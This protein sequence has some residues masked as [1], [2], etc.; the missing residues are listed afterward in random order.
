MLTFER[1]LEVFKDYLAED[2]M[3]EV[4]HTSHGYAILEWDSH[5]K[6][7]N[8]IQHCET[9]EEMRD[10]LLDD[11]AGFM[12]YKITDAERD[13]TEEERG[14]IQFQRQTLMERCR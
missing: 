6:D 1:V 3:Y 10:F 8:G 2:D 11:F 9:P 14:K 5:R 7:W 4:I 12:E 13:I